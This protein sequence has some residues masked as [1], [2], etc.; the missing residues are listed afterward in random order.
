MA[1]ETTLQRADGYGRSLVP[2]GCALLAIGV[3]CGLVQVVLIRQLLVVCSGSELTVGLILAIWMLGGALG[4]LWGGRQARRDAN[5]SRTAARLVFLCSLCL[6]LSLSAASFVRVS[7][8]LFPH[9]PGLLTA[10]RGEVLGLVQTLL[11]T[12]MATLPV[13]FALE[14]AFGSALGIYGALK[15]TEHAAAQCYAIDAVGHLIGG[16]AAAY[17]LTFW[18]DAHT[19]L[20]GV[21]LL[22]LLAATRLRCSLPEGEGRSRR[23]TFAVLVAA[24][25]ATLLGARALDRATLAV[26]WRG[27]TLI[28]NTE[29]LQSNIAVARHGAQGKVFFINGVPTAYTETMPST[30]LLVHFTMLQHPHPQSVLLLGGLGTGAVEEVL[31]HSPTRVDYFELDPALLDIYERHRGGLP[32]APVV[33]HKTDLRAWLRAN[34]GSQ[35]ARWDAIIIALPSPLSAVVNRHYTRECY[36]QLLAESPRAVLGLQL[37]G[38]QTYY[39]ADL[40]R[41]DVG[42]LEAAAVREGGTTALMPGYSLFAALGPEGAQPVTDPHTVL[43]RLAERRVSAAYWESVIIDLLEPMNVRFVTNQ[44]AGHPAPPRNTDLRPISYFH[45]QVY[46]MKQV[47]PVGAGLLDACARLRLPAL[48]VAG[49]VVGLVVAV[50]VLLYGGARFIAVPA[51]VAGTGFIGM[52][53]QLGIIYSFQV[54]VGHI[55]SLIGLLSGG[56]MVGLAAGGLIGTRLLP[57]RCRG[58]SPVT[59]LGAAVALLALS[60]LAFTGIVD[61]LVAA[62]GGMESWA[63]VTGFVLLSV[64]VGGLV[65]V[66][67][68]LATEAVA[69]EANRGPAAAAMYGADLAG[70]GCGALVA[71]A[72]LVP[73]FGLSGC[74][75]LCGVIA[76]ALGCICVARTRA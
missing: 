61:L 48:L 28:E 36:E 34:A 23:A 6:L 73:L 30:H 9:L 31:K 66:Q 41:L 16:G 3:A 71:G 54:H 52:V 65:G 51:V 19:A 45:N 32:G 49:A 11:L 10:Q 75:L 8:E 12:I 1:T 29:T 21:G 72:I 47:D 59:A 50:L 53:L 43:D 27:Y 69:A 67:F 7:P 39:S 18:L 58:L 56:F 17:I 13:V 70:A 46:A 63:L 64:F 74:G 22:S 37:P 5:P 15:P 33:I 44:L 35:R 57:G 62:L 25:C 24:G 40:L 4:V 55:Y 68:P 60:S 26:R 38:T 2:A 42:L 14:A 20:V 76:C